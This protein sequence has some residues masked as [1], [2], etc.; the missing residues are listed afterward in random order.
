MKQKPTNWKAV[1]W[2]DKCNRPIFDKT[3]HGNK[4]KMNKEDTL[5]TNKYKSTDITKI[6]R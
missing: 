3:N 4:E 5:W 6:K 1:N 2:K